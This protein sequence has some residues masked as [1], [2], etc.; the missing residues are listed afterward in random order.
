L[1]SNSKVIKKREI[2]LNK[3]DI[4][5]KQKEMNLIGIEIDQETMSRKHNYQDHI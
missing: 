1:I 4:R 5:T 2:P 3:S